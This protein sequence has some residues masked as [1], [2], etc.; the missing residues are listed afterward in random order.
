MMKMLN[1]VLEVVVVMGAR[2]T[3]T[4]ASAEEDFDEREKWRIVIMGLLESV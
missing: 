2:A 3:T 4:E 1:G